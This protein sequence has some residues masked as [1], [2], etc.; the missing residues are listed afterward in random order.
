MDQDFVKKAP[1]Y[2]VLGKQHLEQQQRQ[3]LDPAKLEKKSAGK[4]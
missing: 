3:H 4:K 2:T 1:T